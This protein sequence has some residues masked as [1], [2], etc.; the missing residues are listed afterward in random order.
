MPS[1][2][3]AHIPANDVLPLDS[4]H[5]A[6]STPEDLVFAA[7]SP[8]DIQDL[9]DSPCRTLDAEYKSWRNLDHPEDRA[10]LA[11]DLAA[12]ANHGGGF[13]VFGFDERSLAP[14]EADPFRTNCT[15]DR[16]ASIVQTY[17]DPPVA[18]S[19]VN[20]LSPLG[21]VHPVI[22]VGGHGVVP[23]CIRNDG[24]VVAGEK[25]VERG[26]FYVRKHG[27]F[28]AGHTFGIPTAR[29][30]K[31]DI[32]QD[33][34]PLIRRCVRRDREALMGQIEATI[35]GRSAA[36]DTVQ[37][38]RTWH[39]AARSAF[40]AL[41]PRSPVA[42]SLGRRHY[43]LSYGLDLGRPEILDHAQLPERLRRAVH[44]VQAVFPSSWS[45][46]DPPYRRGVQARF[47]TD[48]ATGD[49][50]MDFLE[51]AWLRA[52][53]P[54]ETADFWRVSPRGMATIVRGFAED[55]I[56]PGSVS[57]MRPGLYL[58]PGVLG[59]EIAE[60]VT[61]A[62][63]LSRLFAHARQVVFRCEWWGLAGRELYDPEDQ[64]VH[65]GPALGDH[66]VATARVPVSR[67]A[68]AWPEVVAALIAPPLRA[69][70]A[71]LGLDAD[72]VRSQ[73]E[74]WSGEG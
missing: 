50:D 40:L 64:W 41:V 37:R 49:D 11:R 63:V 31:I 16:V 56:P 18:F 47:L 65:R 74:R 42:E 38:L 39:R 6:L 53:T 62:R 73:A 59:R 15:S 44:E 54:N 58:S 30:C 7:A 9:V 34:A 19:V 23:V 17:L 3:Y 32:A 33:W 60:L 70:E 1:E 25:L 27:P 35:E 48:P 66:C 55:I 69:V 61:H 43:V 52:R 26:A 68:Q 22:R 21:V 12:L 45:M 10:E 4:G 14:D 57:S 72:W 2:A 51:T 20:V 8:S 28:G 71:D 29:S 36:P 5:G 67:L 13:V 24:P 46:F